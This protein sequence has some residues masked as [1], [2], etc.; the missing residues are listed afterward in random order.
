[1]KGFQVL[2]LMLKGLQAAKTI[3]T[4]KIYPS[5]DNKNIKREKHLS[6]CILG[7]KASDYIS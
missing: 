2:I 5:V 3:D 1:M 7:Q 6:N 4:T